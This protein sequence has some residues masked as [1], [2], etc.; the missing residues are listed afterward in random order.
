MARRDQQGA[1]SGFGGRRMI[2]R[3]AWLAVIAGAPVSALGQLVPPPTE[4]PAA[5]PLVTPMTLPPSQ[6]EPARQEAE[7]RRRTAEQEAR[8]RLELQQT[9]EQ[10]PPLPYDSLVHLD[11]NG[12]IIPL[13]TNPHLLAL[14]VNPLMDDS[15][16]ERCQG[17]IAERRARMEDAVIKNIDLVQQVLDGAIERADVTDRESIGALVAIVRPFQEMGHLTE[18]LKAQS[19]LSQQQYGFNWK[20]VREYEQARQQELMADAAANT[21]PNA[22]NPMTL[23][24]RQ[25]MGE[26]VRE[27]MA[28]YDGLL[29]E[30]AGRIDAAMAGITL[31]PDK[32]A[33]AASMLSALR[34][35]PSDEARLAAAREL[36]GLMSAAQKGQFLTNVVQSR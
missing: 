26:Y 3:A 30:G 20:I 2:A 10:L 18:D 14:A 15:G 7:Q 31:A 11:A 35:A 32:A 33:Q 23:V 9:I 36:T 19:Y 22:P 24:T 16:L 34:S 25:I 4:A 13:T 8:E 27:P 17:V 12:K 29:I 5:T 21:D 6:T 1:A 28:A